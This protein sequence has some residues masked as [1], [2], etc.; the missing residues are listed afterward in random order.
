MTAE[1]PD[2]LR[3]DD[4]EP[5][6]WWSTCPDCEHEQGDM[7]NG[8]ECEECGAGPMPTLPQ[9]YQEAG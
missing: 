7:G 9:D 5:E 6:I 8:V 2:G 4:D 3:Q 1:L